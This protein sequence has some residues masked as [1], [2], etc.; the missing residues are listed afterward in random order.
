MDAGIKKRN[1]PLDRD[2][3]I[4]VINEELISKSIAKQRIVVDKISLAP[5]I[6][7]SFKRLKSPFVIYSI[8]WLILLYKFSIFHN[9]FTDIRTIENL[10]GF[11]HLRVLKLDNNNIKKI[12]NLTS[13]VTLEVLG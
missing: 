8:F 3:I 6:V 4:K 7:L 5:S 10:Q 11:T 1:K 13:L 9:F 12:E 2:A